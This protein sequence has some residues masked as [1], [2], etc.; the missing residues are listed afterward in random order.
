MVAC[1]NGTHSH[2]F[3]LVLLLLLL[4]LLLLP[5]SHQLQRAA[6]L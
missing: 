2:L 4:L 5:Q 3:H 6:V 1:L